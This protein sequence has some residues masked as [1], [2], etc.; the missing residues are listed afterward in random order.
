MKVSPSILSIIGPIRRKIGCCRTRHR[1]PRSPACFHPAAPGGNSR[2][3]PFMPSN[4][5]LVL[6]YPLSCT[7]TMVIFPLPTFLLSRFPQV[8]QAL[9]EPEDGS[10]YTIFA[11][12]SSL[13]QGRPVRPVLQFVDPVHKWPLPGRPWRPKA[14]DLTQSPASGSRSR[15]P[16]KQTP[17]R[18][19]RM[20]FTI[21]MFFGL[22]VGTK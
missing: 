18:T 4:S 19:R 13:Y 12:G 10:L 9:L 21:F 2:T 17:A 15:P 6:M 16:P 3:L 8:Y 14:F 1:V 11:F 5:S 7:S 20:R 22:K